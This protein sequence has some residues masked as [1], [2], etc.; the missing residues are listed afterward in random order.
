LFRLAQ[1]KCYVTYR[2]QVEIRLRQ[3]PVVPEYCCFM[4]NSKRQKKLEEETD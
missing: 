3:I 1:S 4:P 2:A